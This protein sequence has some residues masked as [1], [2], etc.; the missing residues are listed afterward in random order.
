MAAKP[1]Y[2]EAVIFDMD[3]VIIDSEHVWVSVMQDFFREHG[4]VYTEE[5]REKMMGSSAM[6]EGQF[7]KQVLE[8]GDEWTPQRVS[9]TIEQ[10]VRRRYETKLKLIEGYRELMDQIKQTPMRRGLASGSSDKLIKYSFDRF[11]LHDDFEVALSS[12]SVAAPKPAPDVF[13]EAAKQLGA[14]PSKCV[15]IEDSTNGVRSL[16]AAGMKAIATPDHLLKDHPVFSQADVVHSALKEI[17]L[18]DFKL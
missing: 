17:T 9:E 3:G 13:L 8:L 1:N 10:E 6:F 5:V 2:A 11:G 7:V 4:S 15:G 12:E 16:K 18:E 14:D